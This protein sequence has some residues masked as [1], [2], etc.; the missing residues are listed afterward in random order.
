M[1]IT[2]SDHAA[3]VI[4]A[5]ALAVADAIRSATV[6]AT[7][8][9]GSAPAAL[10][11]VAA[12]PDMTIDDLRRALDLT[13]PG[14]V[15]LVDRLEGRGWLTRRSGHGRTVHL[16]LTAPGRHTHQRLLDARG[17]AIAALTATLDPTDLERVAQLVSPSLTASATDTDQ[18]RHL[19]RLCRRRDCDP[20]PVAARCGAP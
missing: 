16:R 7:G 8:I 2:D 17:Q 5:W 10:V 4:G 11:A 6:A 13:H 1:H 18:L 14:A 3:N 20:C 19:C 12:D 9:T 15:R